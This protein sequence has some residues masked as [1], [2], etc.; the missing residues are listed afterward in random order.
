QWGYNRDG[1]ELPQINMGM[2]CS[3]ESGLPFFYN[4]FP[5]SIVDAGTIKNTLKYMEE[6][7]LQ[8]FTLIMVYQI[9]CADYLH[10]NNASHE[11]QITFFIDYEF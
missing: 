5:G 4:T 9:Y 10:A 6:Y 2:V 7:K 3:R 11:K 8:N 1:E